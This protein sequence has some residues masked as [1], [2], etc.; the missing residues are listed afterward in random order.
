MARITATVIFEYEV[1]EAGFPGGMNESDI[2]REKEILVKMI[3]ADF[4][5]ERVEGRVA[6]ISLEVI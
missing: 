4:R 3:E 2:V 5:R 1:D 6:E